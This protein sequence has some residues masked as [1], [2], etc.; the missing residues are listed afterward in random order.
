MF[1]FFV[2]MGHYSSNHDAPD[3]FFE[4][5]VNTILPVQSRKG[6]GVNQIFLC[7]RF[8]SGLFCSENSATYNTVD[9]SDV[10]STY[11]S[12]KNIVSNIKADGL[13]RRP[14]SNRSPNIHQPV[15]FWRRSRPRT[16][17][18]RRS[19]AEKGVARWSI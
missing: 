9:A 5:F 14:R 7:Y 11:R 1:V 10:A 16:S 19:K 3:M 12:P 17:K 13:T 6:R 4:S 15:A 18:L 2:S 8:T